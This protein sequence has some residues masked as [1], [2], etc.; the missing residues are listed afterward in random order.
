MRIHQET[1]RLK[2]TESAF[3]SAPFLFGTNKRQE[4][5][6]LIYELSKIKNTPPSSLLKQALEGVKF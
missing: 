5:T 2:E 1:K 4:L 6:R 3:A